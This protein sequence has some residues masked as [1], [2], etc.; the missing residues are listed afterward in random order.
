MTIKIIKEKIT[1]QE[2]IDVTRE[3]YG[4][5]IKGVVDIEKEIIALGGEFHS[6]A[7]VVLVEQEGSNQEDIWGINIYPEKE[8]NEWLEFNS[9]V[10]IKP[11]K[12]NRD[13]EIESEEIKDKI[14]DITNRLIE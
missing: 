6:D 3:N 14:K 9:L 4:D 12:N 8:K 1:R 5:M 10:N 13:V 2:L 7:S 11:L